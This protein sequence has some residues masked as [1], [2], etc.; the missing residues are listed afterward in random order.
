MSAAE[1]KELLRPLLALA[2][3][4]DPARHAELLEQLQTLA[5][6]DAL[7]SE[8]DYVNASKF[9]LRVAQVLEALAQNP[10]P[11]AR[12]AFLALTTSEVFLA[13]DE[14]TMSLVRASVSIRP[15]PPPLVAFWDRQCQPEDG[16]TPTTITVL[17]DNGSEAA[18]ALFEAKMLDPAHEDDD[19]IAWMRTRVLAHR[20]DL[21]LL[22]SCERLLVALPE[23]LQPLLVEALFDY[24]PEEWFRPAVGASAPPLEAASRE[25][26]DQVLKVGVVALTMVPL[27]LEQRAVVKVRMDAA[28]GLRNRWPR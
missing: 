3:G 26:L 19:K 21:A 25:Q 20:N 5:V 2:R 18:L 27:S 16:F 14:R 6:L 28:E 8:A 23:H 17:I 9:R 7:D 11:S 10:A 13:H 1:A 24:R 4:D 12:A 22:E 15:A